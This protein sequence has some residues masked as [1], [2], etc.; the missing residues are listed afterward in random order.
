MEIDTSTKVQIAKTA[1]KVK[2][3]LD[4]WKGENWF[5]LSNWEEL[6]PPMTKRFQMLK[7]KGFDGYEGDNAQMDSQ[8][9]K[10]M[11][12]ENIDYVNWLAEEAHN[13]GLL[14]F[15]KNGGDSL[16]E[17]VVDVYDG[18]IVESAIRYKEVEPYKAFSDQGKPTWFFEYD[19][20]KSRI[21]SG[22]KE[23][24]SDVFLDTKNGW[25]RI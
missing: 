19:I 12:K 13:Q 20:S 11:H 22:K 15:L 24:M 6:K 4:G 5:K 25:E 3:C 21:T 23:W 1:H 10:G 17:D 18:V 14:A 9:N 8:D 2:G 7:N 16:V